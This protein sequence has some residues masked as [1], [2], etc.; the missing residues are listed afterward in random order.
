MPDLITNP[1]DIHLNEQDEMMHFIGKP[2]SVF[3]RFGIYVAL[4][5]WV[6]LGIRYEE[7][8]SRK[9]FALKFI[10]NKMKFWNPFK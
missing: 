10:F 1:N 4:L 5:V 6:V 3:M 2:P 7:N 8:G 9:R